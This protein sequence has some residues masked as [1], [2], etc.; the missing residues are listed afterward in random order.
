VD[1]GRVIPNLGA[2]DRWL[3]IDALVGQLILSG[4]VGEGDRKAIADAVCRREK[5]RSTGIGS[6]LAIPH[7]RTPLVPEVAW[8]FG[9]SRAGIAFEAFDGQP[10]YFIFLFLVPEAQFERHVQTLARIARVFKGD[11]VLRD[12]ENA[13][14]AA[15]ITRILESRL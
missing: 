4:Q 13:P 15:A 5:S 8:V 14:D 7:A 10:V 9:R 12:L 1:T 6:G 3:A 2:A 11:Q